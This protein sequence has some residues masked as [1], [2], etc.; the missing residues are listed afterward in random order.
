MSIRKEEAPSHCSLVVPE[1]W[2]LKD[3]REVV[4]L[5]GVELGG[6]YPRTAPGPDDDD[7]DLSDHIR[8]RCDV[9]LMQT[10]PCT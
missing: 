10:Y 9:N 7:L 3:Q 1:E 5:H 8:V 6:R 4:Q 2:M